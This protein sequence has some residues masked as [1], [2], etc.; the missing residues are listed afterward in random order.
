M[1]SNQYDIVIIGSGMGG[2][3]SAVLLGMEGYKVLV[4]EKNHQ[5][6]GNLQVFS[7]DKVIFDTGVHYIGSLDKGENLY[8]IFK[9]M[10]I[11]DQLEMH[12]LDE[13]GFDYIRF[14]NG[15]TIPYG[16]GYERLKS[17][18]LGHF[19]EE[20]VAID[21]FYEK[22]QEMCASFPLY[23]LEEDVEQS[24]L[25][26]P[27]LLEI[28][29]WE[30]ANSLTNNKRLVAFFLGSGILY[31]GEKGI[32]PFY[33]LAL[34]INSYINGSYRLVN[35]GAQLTKALIGRI[36]ELGG[37]ILKH[38]EVV[39]AEYEGDYVRAVVTAEGKRYEGKYFISNVHPMQTV[40]IFG[41]ERFRKAFVNRL[42]RN[43]NTT[44]AFILYLSLKEQTVP[45][46]NHNYYDFFVPEE[47]AWSITEYEDATWPQAFFVSCPVERNQ[48]KY[49]NSMIAMAYMK[50]DE[51]QQWQDSFNTIANKQGRGEAYENWK[52]EKEQRI[53]D[54]LE[55]RY[56]GI[57]ANIKGIYSATPL[58]NRDY[59][60]TEDGSI[61]GIR[62]DVRNIIASKIDT[63][64]KIPNVFLTGQN[65][66]FHGILGTAIGA[67]VTSFNFVDNKAL[68]EKIKSA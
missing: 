50:Y 34:I 6:G 9:Y 47:E 62:K 17:Q 58:T 20:K 36:R 31:A 15:D 46:F 55:E 26:Y 56:P 38:Q 54:K 57:R 8:Q 37:D 12:R 45:Y 39:E 16:Q 22:V 14:Q 65:I 51:V 4:L 68:I 59:I 25:R 64:T 5:V 3:T 18:L 67:I 21:T 40:D 42:R 48:G 32:T 30:F 52:K 11:L 60:G 44:S 66:I 53:L 61:Y 63:R 10:G 19:P 29:A 49:T 23:N 1:T 35:G 13:D 27:E 43:K 24:Y 33:V 41:A 28:D 2:L 7:R